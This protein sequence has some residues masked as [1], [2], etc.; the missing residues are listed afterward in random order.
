[1]KLLLIGLLPAAIGFLLT[2]ALGG[3]TR[4]I[5]RHDVFKLII[6][7]GI[8]VGLCSECYFAGL[9]ASIPGPL[10][11]LLLAVAVVIAV[12]LNRNKT[13]C[14]FCERPSRAPEDRTLT[15]YLAAAFAFLLLLDLAIFIWVSERNPR[16]GWDAWA[17]W[18]LRAHFLYRAGGSAWR[19]A[20]TEVLA[21][22]HPDY[23]LLL[24]A[25]VARGWRLLGRESSMVPVA[26]A[27]FF[28]FGCAGLMA[29]GVTILRGARQGFLAGLALAA[30]PFL[31]VQGAMQCADVPVAF[32]ILATLVSLALADRFNSRGFAAIAGM[33]AALAG[34]TKNEG[35]LWFG[36]ILLARILMARGRSLQP[37]LAGAL[38]VLAPVIFFKAC[39]AT[40]SDIFGSAGRAGMIARVLD[41]NRYLLIA[42]EAFRHIRDFGPLPVSAFAILA[43][44]LAIAGLQ[45]DKR[46]RDILRT[47]TLAL[48]LSAVGYCL[49]YLLRPL[50]LAWLLDTS[51]DRL[52]LQIWP[53][54]VFAVFLASRS[55][56]VP[57]VLPDFPF[58]ACR[59]D[60]QLEHPLDG[61]LQ[62]VFCRADWQGYPL[63]PA[64]PS[65]LGSSCFATCGLVAARPLCGAPSKIW[66][67]IGKPI[68]T[69]ASGDL[70]P[71]RRRLRGP[72][73]GDAAENRGGAESAHR[74]SLHPDTAISVAAWDR[75]RLL[76]Q[77]RQQP[78]SFPSRRLHGARLPSHRICVP[79]AERPGHRL[80]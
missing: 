11:E 79:V 44:Y 30:T 32:F 73:A 21:W 60:S 25:F 48:S 68:G 13:R 55:L 38:P 4:R 16:G 59:D 15:R 22:S 14:R 40:A 28:T 75:S 23:P 77:A 52:L 29:S 18:N 47:S 34:W 57:D 67:S 17:I 26:L 46:D 51:A 80:A 20:F 72:L 64:Q 8:G 6:G 27:C 1:M 19:D 43:V 2:R 45:R 63:D 42:K 74:D 35:L 7:T 31:Y 9:V 56:T 37:F 12:C 65:L 71:R 36:A 50:D 70:P 39:V 69:T 61:H 58:L 78:A 49:I 54:I 33:A 41:P 53:G 10:P 76:Y 24:P 3:G 62:T 5:C 66:R